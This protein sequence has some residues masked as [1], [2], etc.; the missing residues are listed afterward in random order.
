MNNKQSSQS[1]AYASVIKHFRCEC[2]WHHTQTVHSKVHFRIYIIITMIIITYAFM[3]VCV[4]L[5]GWMDGSR[6]Q[7]RS[8][9]QTDSAV[10]PYHMQLLNHVWWHLVLPILQNAWK[11]WLDGSRV[12]WQWTLSAWVRLHLSCNHSLHKLKGCCLM[13]PKF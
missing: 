10:I 13:S 1:P 11:L 9:H 6:I 7:Y 3:N 4:F 12:K 5:D 8:K 2:L